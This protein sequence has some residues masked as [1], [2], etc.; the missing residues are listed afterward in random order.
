MP[1]GYAVSDVLRDEVI[2]MGKQSLKIPAIAVETG[3]SVPTIY[4]ILRHAGVL[5][6]GPLPRHLSSMNPVDL[7]SVIKAYIST[8]E[9]VADIV[10]RFHITVQDLYTILREADIPVRSVHQKT[11][12]IKNLDKAIAMYTNEDE[13]FALWEIE[14]QTGVTAQRLNRQLHHLRIPLRRQRG[15]KK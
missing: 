1:K 5:D 15:R 10:D 4:K 3:L 12:A 9:T 8:T 2:E 6:D 11:N 14:Q 7:D 13:N